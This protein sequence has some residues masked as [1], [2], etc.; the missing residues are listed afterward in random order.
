MSHG[1]A[2]SRKPKALVNGSRIAPI[3]PASPADAE[4][5]AK[6][7]QELGR[8]G[9]LTADCVPAAPEAYFSSSG[10]E[11]RK[12]FL[13]AVADP[14][15][16]GLI[17]LRGGYGSAYLLDEPFPAGL[18]KPK[19]L[20]GYSDMTSLQIVLWQQFRW[21][22]FYGPMVAAGFHASAGR[23]G[24]YDEAS[25]LRAVRE[26]A[27]GWSLDLQGEA[28]R[29]GEAKGRLLGGCLTLVETSIGTPWQLATRGAILVLEDRGMKPW[30]VDRALMHLKQAG[31]FA[32][33][34]GILLGEFPECEPP[35]A[36]SWSAADVCRRLLGPL[37]IPVVW[38]APVGHTTRP[39]LTLP[40]G[41]NVRLR[42]RGAGT[43]EILEPAVTA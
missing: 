4:K 19:C 21:I 1:R 14:S 27:S 28:I 22:T 8:L 20:V 15:L 25:F 13:R 9:F 32:G 40:L 5:T 39:M 29:T 43:L 42:A 30:Q 18:R 17:A 31:L 23:P 7:L 16:A 6:G 38:G 24:G 10:M 34:R 3:A 41:V 33:V 37:G 36:G 26:T 35:V 2:L 11:R 12:E